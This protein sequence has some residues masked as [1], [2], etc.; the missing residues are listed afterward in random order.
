M[1]FSGVLFDGNGFSS[2][3]CQMG[4]DV[5]RSLWFSVVVN[6]SVEGFFKGARGLRQGDPLSPLYLCYL[7]ISRLL[8]KL[9]EGRLVRYHPMSEVV[10][11]THLLFADDVEFLQ[12]IFCGTDYKSVQ[13]LSVA[14]R[15]FEKA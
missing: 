9:Y 13:H 7:W 3:V 6:G 5:C 1:E 11:I 14:L 2:L 10:G 15:V 8:R 12:M 4:H